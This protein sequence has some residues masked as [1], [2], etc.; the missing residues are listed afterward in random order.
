MADDEGWCT[1]T[2]TRSRSRRSHLSSKNS[3]GKT[4]PASKALS[5]TNRFKVLRSMDELKLNEPVMIDQHT[6]ENC[7]ERRA[8]KAEERAKRE[9]REAKV[10][11]RRKELKAEK[12][13][14]KRREREEKIK[15]KVEAAVEKRE[16]SATIHPKERL[17]P[18]REAER[19]EE[20]QEKQE[21]E[22]HD[23]EWDEIQEEALL[24]AD[25][26]EG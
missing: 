23:N 17:S 10:E 16:A 8:E 2:R 12:S 1:V 21:D 15:K 4:G 18:V 14:R 13:A 7:G 24:F 25:Q 3:S 6:K 5:D 20:L 22:W 11:V 9:E 19:E 26:E